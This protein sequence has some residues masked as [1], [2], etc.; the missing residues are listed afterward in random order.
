M[1][2]LS[3]AQE[4]RN[5]GI[6][7]LPVRSGT[8]AAAVS[9]RE[10]QTRLPLDGELL[11]WFGSNAFTSYAIMT[12]WQGLTVIDFDDL[13]AYLK[14]QT[15]ANE[16]GGIPQ[17]IAHHTYQ[18]VTS[19]GVHVYVYSHDRVNGKF[20]GGDVQQGEHYVL[21][22]GSIHPS[23]AIYRA[24]DADAPILPVDDLA[25][26]FPGVTRSADN[27]VTPPSILGRGIPVSRPSIGGDA[28]AALNDP[29]SPQ[30]LIDTARCVPLADILGLDVRE[31]GQNAA[32]HKMGMAR[33]PMHDDRA[34]SL[35]VDLTTNRAHCFAGCAPNVAGCDPRKGFGSIDALMWRE[36]LAF[37]PAVRRLAGVA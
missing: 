4:W 18:V 7:C 33:C 8:K 11:K 35:S 34:P 26:V 24:I 10:Y 21:G 5:R 29:R 22:A 25:A 30:E 3:M 28:W 23:G 9:W 32:G 13:A 15:W 27:P 31:S 6:P 20:P 14:W 16:Q 2:L 17:C 12:G 37:W 36:H 1:E 19:R